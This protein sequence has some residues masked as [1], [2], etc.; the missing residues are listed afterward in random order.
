MGPTSST[1]DPSTL[2][3][4]L[5]GSGSLEVSSSAFSSSTF[6]RVSIEEHCVEICVVSNKRSSKIR[7]TGVAVSSTSVDGFSLAETSGAAS[8]I[9]S[10]DSSFSLFSS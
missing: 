1:T 5:T 7:T 10:D 8:T 4:S 9:G 2:A 3:F 6:Q